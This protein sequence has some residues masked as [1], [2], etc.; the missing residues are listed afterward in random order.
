MLRRVF[1]LPVRDCQL[2]FLDKRF[3]ATEARHETSLIRNMALV[4]HIGASVR[5]SLVNQSEKTQTLEKLRL[6]SLYYTSRL[7]WYLLAQLTLAALRQTS[8][9]LNENAVSQFN[10][11]AFQSNGANGLLIL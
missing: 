9:L 11:R 10:L 7:T 6:P 4:A 1:W 3:L 5:A 2:K 8:C